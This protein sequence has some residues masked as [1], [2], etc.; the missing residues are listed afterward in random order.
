M[1]QPR[2]PVCTGYGVS[3]HIGQPGEVLVGGLCAECRAEKKASKS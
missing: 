3:L 2:A 1:T